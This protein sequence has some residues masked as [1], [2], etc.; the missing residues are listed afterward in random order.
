MRNDALRIV[1]LTGVVMILVGPVA[2]GDPLSIYEL[3]Y[4]TNPTGESEYVDQV[5]DCSGGIVILKF[6]GF[7]PRVILYDPAHPDAWGG[8]QVKDW[9]TTLDLFDHVELGDWISLTNVTVEEFRGTTFLQW[10]TTED[11]GFTI[12]SQG[13]AIPDPIGDHRGGHPR[14]RRGATRG[15]ARRGSCRRAARKHVRLA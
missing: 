1:A 11:P 4:T 12:V 8:I 9:S 2:L 15:V 5:V 10:Y 6:A 14:A 7:R 13:H 3:Q